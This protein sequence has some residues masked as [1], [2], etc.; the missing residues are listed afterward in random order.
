MVEPQLVSFNG[1]T[2]LWQPSRSKPEKFLVLI[3][4]WTGDENSMWVFAEHLPE[5]YSFLSPRAPYPAPEGG[6][7]W[8]KMDQGQWGKPA[9]SDL[10]PALDE[11]F[12]LIDSWTANKEMK[13]AKMDLVGFSQGAAMVCLMAALYPDRVGKVAALS[14]FLPENSASFLAGKPLIGKRF[15]VSHGRQD[16]L[17]PVQRAHAAV[18]AL[19]GAG[20][21]VTY[22]ETDGGHKVSKDCMQTLQVFFR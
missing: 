4:G 20:A 7:T 8:R 15:F 2:F 3:H 6:F 12:K 17:V 10:M 21:D 5:C 22:C 9:S 13:S 11:L 18:G 16:E 1:W 14:G 19:K